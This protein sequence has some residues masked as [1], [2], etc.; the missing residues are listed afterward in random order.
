MLWGIDRD[1]WISVW[2]GALGAIPAAVLAAAVAAWVAVTVLNR[3][4]LHQRQQADK[5]A[6][7]QR[8]IARRQ[9][10]AERLSAQRALREQRAQ[11]Q[12]QLTEQRVLADRQLSEQRVLAERQMSEQRKAASAGR[13][14]QAIAEVLIATEDFMEIPS[15]SADAAALQFRAWRAAVARWRAELGTDEMQS[16][17]L[18]WTS[19]FSAVVD[20][21]MSELEAGRTERGRAVGPVLSM[22]MAAISGTALSWQSADG[23]RRESLRGHLA[24]QRQRIQASL[25]SIIDGFEA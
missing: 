12:K 5:A 18:Q 23:P 16:E 22:A 13:E 3:S 11:L 14:Q 10:I 9:A 2:S 20:S 6:R 1:A 21:L 4:N 15:G 19:V 8:T 24:E 17:L 7:E 25:D